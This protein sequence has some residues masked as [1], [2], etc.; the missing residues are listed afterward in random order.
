MG[1]VCEFTV[2]DKPAKVD[3]DEWPTMVKF[4]VN[5]RF[6]EEAQERRAYEY[7]EYMNKHITVIP[8]IGA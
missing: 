5:Y 8:P 7:A 3:A 6:D 4:P 2:T 1:Q